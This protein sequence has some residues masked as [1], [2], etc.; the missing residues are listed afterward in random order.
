MKKTLCLFVALILVMAPSAAFSQD[1]ES[2]ANVIAETMV[3][4][5]QIGIGDILEITTWKEEDFSLEAILVRIDGKIT[6]PLLDDVQAAGL[7]PLQLK[8]DLEEKL[9]KYVAAPV[10]TVSVVN[11]NS[12]KFY[13]NSKTFYYNSKE[14]NPI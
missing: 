12:K 5:Y 4:T 8:K 13:P 6:F 14:L 2:K 11:P 3:E 10:V 9:K 1:K 7:S